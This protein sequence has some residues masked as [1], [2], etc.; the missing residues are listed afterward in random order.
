MATIWG[1]A[2]GLISAGDKFVSAIQSGSSGQWGDAKVSATQSLNALIGAL[3]DS[4][5]FKYS[6][7]A[8]ALYDLN[9]SFGNLYNATNALDALRYTADA[10]A[11]VG[12]LMA[13]APAP[14]AKA[15]G[16]AL[17][18]GM[19]AIK[20]GI[21]TYQGSGSAG[22]IELPSVVIPYLPP[23]VKEY[24]WW[25]I[26][27]GILSP[28]IGATPDPLIRVIRYV[29]PLVLDLD[30]DGLEI[31]PL[32]HGVVFDANGD[33]IKNGTAWIGGDD[34]LLVWDRNGNGSIDSGVELFGDET[35]LADGLKAP[36]G[37]AALSDIDRGSVVNGAAVGARDGVFDARDAEYTSLRIWRDV[38]QDG[39]S[40]A[41][42]LTNLAEAG[43]Q[44]IGLSS[45]P[46]PNA[47]YQDAILARNGSFTR[48]SGS[49]GQA[50]SF[51]LVQN[52]F[53]SQ[54][55]P[56]EVSGAAEALPDITGTGWVRN[57][58]EAATVSP[59]LIALI[60]SVQS[61]GPRSEYTN[62]VSNLLREWGNDSV[63]NNAS[64]QAL[65]AG[66][67]LILS[68]PVGE[69]ERGW[70]DLAI[71]ANEV[72]RNTFRESLSDTDR[73]KFDAMRERM[74]G[75]LERLYAYEA[76]TGHTFLTWSQ[77]HDDATNFVP[78]PVQTWGRLIETSVPFSQVLH[79]NR[80]AVPASQ[81]GYIR[82]DI[83]LPPANTPEPYLNSLWNRLVND[84][85]TSL[86]ASMRL[87][88]YLDMVDVSVSEQRVVFDFTRL[89]EA[90]IEA[91]AASAH[92]GAAL[93]LDVY[94]VFGDMLN[95]LGWS[96]AAQMNAL[97]QRAVTDA[98]V[99]RALAARSINIFGAEA[100][101][102]TDGDDA[103]LGG[104]DFTRFNA[105]AGNDIIYGD[106]GD[107]FLSGD[108]GDDLIF[109]G[110]DNDQ[111]Y[112]GDGHDVY[113]GGLGDD[114]MY[115]SSTSSDDAYRFARG[116]GQDTIADYGGVDRV[117]LMGLNALDVASVRAGYGLTV[118]FTT[119]DSVNVARMFD[120]AGAV[121]SA[122][123]IESL[124]F[125][126]G[127]SWDIA[128]L[129]TEALRG[130]A[131]ED[132]ISGFNTNDHIQGWAGADGL[133][134]L[135]GNDTLDGGDG[136][137]A[138]SGGEGNDVFIGGTGDDRFYDYASSSDIY[139]F[140]RGDGRDYIHDSDGADRYEL[141]NLN[142]VDVQS[143]RRSGGGGSD[144][145]IDF[146]GTD[147]LTLGYAFDWSSGATYASFEN[148]GLYFS[149]GTHWNVDRLRSEAL[150]GTAG[151]DA[152][153]GFET[154]DAINGGEGNDTLQGHG[155]NDI[156]E[157]GHGIDEIQGQFG[158]DT[159]TGGAGDDQMFGDG[160][161]DGAGGNDVLE[162]GAGNDYLVG[163]FGGDT[164]I[165]RRGDGQDTI[166]NGRSAWNRGIAAEA[167][168][169]DVLQF[170]LGIA[171][172]DVLLSRNL[173]DLILRIVES[174][175]Q[176]TIR[177]Y[178]A[179]GGSITN[180]FGYALEAIAF[181]DGTRWGVTDILARM[182]D[183]ATY[184]DDNINGTAGNDIIDAL[185]GNDTVRGQG[186]DDVID[187]GL[188]S[189]VLFGGAGNDI[190][191]V[192]ATGDIASENANEGTDT[193]R[194]AVTWT[195]GANI[196][197][198]TLTGTAN[199]NATGN[200]LTNTLLGNAG[201]NRLDGGAGADAMT[202]NT[203]NDAYLVDNAS[204]T[205]IE[206]AGGGT[207]L[208]EASVSWTLSAEIENLTLTGTAVID[209]TGNTLANTLR[210]NAANNTL[211]GG[212][213]N[214]TMFG[215]LGDDTYVVDA[216]TDVVIESASEGTDTIQTALTWTLG[217]NVENLTLTGNAAVDGA[218][219][220]WAN[221]LTGNSAANRLSGAGGADMLAG[222]AGNDTYVVDA[223]DVV[224][225]LAGGGYDAI[226]SSA[227]HT[228]NAEVE[229]LT[230]TGTSNYNGTGNAS[231]NTLIGN[232]GYNRLDGGLGADAMTGGAGNDTYVV[233]NVG[234]TTLEL[235]AGGTDLVESSIS[236]TLAAEVENLT[237][238]GI[239]AIN[240]IGNTVANTLRGNAGNNVLDG[241]AGSDSMFGGAG[242]DTYV[243]DDAGDRVT[244]L[245]NEGID[246]VQ[247]AVTWT[248]GA[249]LEN[250]TLT[251]TAV[252]DGVGNSVNNV[253]T[254]NAAANRLDGR[255][256]GDTMAGAAGDDVY[257][258][259][260][261]LDVVIEAA[262]QG[263]DRVET[264]LSHTLSA[265]VENLTLT[266]TGDIN[267]T[268]NALA[269]TLIG[270]A[271]INRLDGGAGADTMT[272][273]AGN[274]TY[275]VD[276]AGD[277]L[278]E[279]AG[280]G[281]DTVEA[282]ISWTLGDQLE[283]L[284]L[285]G[286]A[287]INATGN[288]AA[289][290]LRGN[291]GN[292]LLNGLAGNDV[293][294]GGVGNDTYVVDATG[295]VV[296]ENA[297]EGL[298]I[299]QSSVTWT[300]GANLENLMLTGT[301]A[302]NGTGNTQ[303]NMLTGNT[304]ANMLTGGAGNDTLNGGAGN[305]ALIGGAGN[306][307]YVVDAATDVVTE[308]ANEGTDTVESSVTWTL[309]ANVEN[310]VL[311]GTTAINGT[312]NALNNV[313]TGN[314][315]NN[316]LT[317]GA[318]NDTLEGGAGTDTL[319]GGAGEDSYFVDVST[320]VVTENANEG[321]D[322]VNSAVTWTLGN[323]LENLTLTGT[324]AINATGNTLA[325]T[326][327]GNAANNVLNGGTGNDSLLGGAGD[328]TYVVDVATD[329]VTEAANEGTDTV[330]SAVTWT[331]GNNLENLTLTGTTAIN[332]T[333]NALANVLTGN[334]AN[335]TLNG[336][337][338]NDVLD[339][340]T[341]NDTMLGGAG[342]DSYFVNVT[343]DVVTENANEGTDTVNSA[344]T[345]TLGNNL[346]NLTLTGTTAINGTGNAL[347]NTLTGNAAANTLTG[348]EGADIYI[349]G[350]GNDTLT[351]TST[352]SADVYRFGRGDAQDTVR[353]S[354]GS[355]RLEFLSGIATD[356]IWLRRV[357][358]DLEV[359]VI[360]TND[361][362]TVGNW[363]GST[364]NRI[365]TLQTA[366][367]L[368][369]LDSRVQALV[370]AMAAFAPPAVGQTTLPPTY[371]TALSATIAAN[372]QP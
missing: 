73:S 70:M 262:G 183:P 316:T 235:A 90:L 354:G 176:V 103:Y 364:A 108:A 297:N 203:G 327:R 194:S 126:D 328:D 110:E 152:V 82:V 274:D 19:T 192:N 20:R 336:G 337:A 213:G 335:N 29:D 355:D 150:R 247:S 344:V 358:S 240:G 190:Y 116:N 121:D 321:A 169:Q 306:D 252:I 222:G 224:V 160:P 242:N 125:A 238:T 163:G 269:N 291:A 371:S 300:L 246:T 39:I 305:D 36:H 313:L 279:L 264:A 182:P 372:W 94:Q 83:P 253:L 14:H 362:M 138:L 145:A 128:R 171:P 289:N 347:A 281:T 339:G 287:A 84:A 52:N 341:G 249:E 131:G 124:R 272:G 3:T 31:T 58:R 352:T 173:A 133:S 76:F 118:N 329:V 232:A 89:D 111:L 92:E 97:M 55:A 9:A 6:G 227:H 296:T 314:A 280:G 218:G 277:V 154:N 10:L 195:L 191:I 49:P 178:F 236:W 234:D 146:G 193:I 348:G 333:G 119:G 180:G 122:R 315:A 334:S 63:Y 255:A 248:L 95:S 16:I 85:S 135:D 196:E 228:L 98:N 258:V 332:G 91:N 109:G 323:N 41:T 32:G 261:A 205:T 226:E 64:R 181:V 107:D 88:N 112:G 123:A 278:S 81:T 134:G 309:G 114:S 120:Y 275:V 186:G 7:G 127:T 165:F 61:A 270:N 201:N 204:D 144:L 157:G 263:I 324:A 370:D 87:P 241:A 295:D 351:D 276:S 67:G 331:L 99:V 187:G 179:G 37:F 77:V 239:A 1:A 292:N 199:I 260:D 13:L 47:T 284:T 185:D 59:E 30:G 140:G 254:G 158:S 299:V 310:L 57:L 54:F 62:A 233:D 311:T 330:Q 282:S 100:V 271:R 149:D 79:D 141:T 319:V 285:T 2:E 349:G 66:Y 250:L 38:N 288:G 318:G 44:S 115:D 202:G 50:G 129:R 184:A 268:G 177:D 307:T 273:G 143:V 132:I 357:G 159:L 148:D 46:F 106:A 168:K 265:N 338:G 209:A 11:T 308:I 259:D 197:N 113:V 43:V 301:A 368:R 245:V 5:F 96:G 167:G 161:S 71:R 56:L 302:I 139:R 27:D 345:W 24:D 225:E 34:G 216:L 104:T 174:N 257:L 93:F 189:D 350:A 326:L 26:P 212:L 303:D 210:G 346:E 8:S 244:E 72:D 68:E 219:N 172:A 4:G 363:Y 130:T 69:Q 12:S 359:S 80:V 42:E 286:T 18:I 267:A 151:A 153:L 294:L 343:T 60:E 22:D 137:D 105:G 251:G 312:G 214:D 325:N 230:L 166:D 45:Q 136:N 78:R 243:V 237:L 75:G 35:I 353:D 211:D 156:L 208:V 221:V 23:G 340:G 200:E 65:A 188:G 74:I 361:R 33:G 207:D 283:N 21:E 40:Q 28:T 217:G 365:E 170:G 162:G 320:D 266:G 356:Q 366:G 342:D 48:T 86:L 175:D 117:D 17:S 360:G 51:I 290:T 304:A 229:M 15:I 101:V 367:G 317:G 53:V 322:T 142:A 220:G 369:L 155:G 206:A 231:A 102:G 25:S 164:Y 298:D 147:S 198:L 223:T 256:G 215:G 293:M